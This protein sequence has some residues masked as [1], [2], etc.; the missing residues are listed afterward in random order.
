MAIVDEETRRMLL[1]KTWCHGQAILPFYSVAII[2]WWWHMEGRPF[3]LV[4]ASLVLPAWAWFSY[5]A[6]LA[7]D[8][9]ATLPYINFCGFGSAAMVAHLLTF[10]VAVRELS[11]MVHMLMTIASG[12]FF[13]ETCAFLLVVTVFRNEITSYD[14]PLHNEGVLMA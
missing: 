1:R 13:V 10:T 5:R 14:E 12:L 4:L 2:V 8:R 7:L 3:R 9:D 6:V 11:D